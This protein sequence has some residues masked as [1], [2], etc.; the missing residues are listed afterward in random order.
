MTPTATRNGA[1]QGVEL[2]NN[3]GI[4][5]QGKLIAVNKEFGNINFQNQQGSTVEIWDS[6]KLSANQ[7][8]YD[9]FINSKTK[10]FP[11]TNL[12]DGKLTVEESFVLKRA[13]F[14]LVTIVDATGVVSSVRELDLTT[15]PGYAMGQ[16]QFFIVNSR[17]IRPFPIRSFFPQFN[18]N[19]D[20]AE[21]SVKNW[22][23]KLVIPPLMEFKC[24][25]D[26]V[27]G[28]F[29]APAEGSSAYLFMTIGGPG[30]IFA[31]KQNF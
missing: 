27:A 7:L 26:F 6:V 23:T 20:F 3:G 24:Q 22:D 29:T 5:F 18:E 31:P 1:Q 19:S 2:R 10:I 4:S 30:G 13:Y 8:S 12:L 11:F 15:D 17:V 28:F 21:Q 9:F 14:S 25:V 16:L